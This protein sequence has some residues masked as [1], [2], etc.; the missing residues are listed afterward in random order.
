MILSMTGY[1]SVSQTLAPAASSSPSPTAKAAAADASIHATLPGTTTVSVEIRTVNSRFLDIHFRMPD[2]VRGCEPA[3]RELLMAKLSRG[4]VE[5][6]VNVQRAEALASCGGG[7]DSA[8]SAEGKLNQTALMRLAALQRA[9]LAAFPDAATL[10]VADILRWPGVMADHGL[11][12]Q[13]LRDAVLACAR[14]ALRDVIEV[15]RREGDA[16]GAMLHARVIEMEHIVSDITPLVPELIVRHQEKIVDRLQQALGIALQQGERAG[17]SSN[18]SVPAAAPAASGTVAAAPFLSRDEVIERIRQEVTVYG[19]RIDIGE[20]LMRLSTH[21]TE[22]R[23][24]LQKGGKVGK[25]LDFM[26]QELNREANTVGS[27][28]AAKELADAAMALKL[29]IEQMRE[30]VQ[31]L[32]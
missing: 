22:T 23:H 11:D 5:V 19:I 13:A 26:M 7:A 17:T 29:L 27:K 4:K 25:R 2:E 8:G 14:E 9:A 30:Q 32:E 31:N 18:G 28:A 6:R 12:E 10:R 15:R 24:L 3:L 21:L 16:L 1:A 20:E